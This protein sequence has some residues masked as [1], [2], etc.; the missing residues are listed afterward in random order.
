MKEEN[1]EPSDLELSST[2]PFDGEIPLYV[3]PDG[4]V[5]LFLE[6]EQHLAKN[7]FPAQAPNL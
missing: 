6:N 7:P 2:E 4:E 5:T 1:Y 3:P